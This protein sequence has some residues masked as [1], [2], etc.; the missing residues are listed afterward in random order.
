MGQLRK[1]IFLDRDGTINVDYGYLH[2]REQFELLPGAL[3]GLK[4]LREM[5]FGLVIITNQSGIGRGMFTIDDYYDF[6]EFFESELNKNGIT[7][8]GTYFCPHIDADNC[9]CRKP[10]TGLYEKAIEELNIDVK[11]SYAIGDNLRDVAI[12]K[13]IPDIKGYVIGETSMNCETGITYVKSLFDAAMLI[14]ESLT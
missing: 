9:S 13:S 8:L 10:K 7:I 4:L 6:Q 12:C 5:G 1:V 11:K 3:E 2:R 14:K